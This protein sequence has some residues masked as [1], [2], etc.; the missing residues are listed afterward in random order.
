MANGEINA[1][2]LTEETTSTLSGNEQFV[3]FD[4][5]EG[6]RAYID[7]VAKYIA[8]DKS[9][10]QTSEKSSVVGAINEVN[11]KATDLKEDINDNWLLSPSIPNTIQTVS[12]DS[13]GRISGV[14]H[15]RNSTT[16]RQDSISYSTN[17]ITETRTGFGKTIT[18][19]TN[20]T[21]LQTEVA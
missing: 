3:M 15:K 10:L 17:T 5:V 12:F 14:L 4:P 9:Q 7:E 13:S 18:I 2:D 1:T 11:G 19:T 20:L 6:K 8:G 21:T 16:I